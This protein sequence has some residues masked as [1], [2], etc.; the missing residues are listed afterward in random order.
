MV[1]QECGKED[2]T[3]A[4]SHSAVEQRL[5]MWEREDGIME[6]QLFPGER[7]GTHQLKVARSG[8][9]NQ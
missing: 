2:G 9:H 7:S 4:D 6:R 1:G 5:Q 3:G 8:I